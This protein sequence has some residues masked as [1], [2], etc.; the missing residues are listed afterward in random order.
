MKTIDR[1][2]KF[3]EAKDISLNAFDKSIGRPAGYIGKQIRSKASIGSDI[4]ET[5]LRAHKEISPQW[6]IFGEGEMFREKRSPSDV[7]HLMEEKSKYQTP[8]IFEEAMLKYL[9][10]ER[11]QNSINKLIDER[12]KYLGYGEKEKTN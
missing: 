8:D 12:L 2:A 5:I 9:E 6:L 3:I 7:F 1:I 4:V 11:V 10:K